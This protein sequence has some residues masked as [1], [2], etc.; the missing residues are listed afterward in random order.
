[1]LDM[2]FFILGIVNSIFLIAI[3]AVRKSRLG[4]VQRFGWIYLLLAIPGL[5]GI[6]LAATEN[7]WRYGIFLGIFLVF[8]LFEW[9]YDYVLKINF[10]ENLKRYWRWTGPYLALYYMMNYGFVVMPWRDSLPWGLVM[11]GLFVIQ[12]VLNLL[13]HPRLKDLAGEKNRAGPIEQ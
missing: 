3:F 12:I 2:F 9:L 10:R 13:S 4:L 8:L 5:Y 11:V 1:M 6:Y 7:S